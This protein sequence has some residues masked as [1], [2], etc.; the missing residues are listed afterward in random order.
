VG[1]S[2]S[3]PSLD[4][5]LALLPGVCEKVRSGAYSGWAYRSMVYG[6][7]MLLMVNNGNALDDFPR[8]PSANFPRGHADM[9]RECS[10]QTCR[11]VSGATISWLP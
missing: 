6:E 2:E 11:C 9:S 7:V 5:R 4:V 1:D 8:S 3:C 10:T